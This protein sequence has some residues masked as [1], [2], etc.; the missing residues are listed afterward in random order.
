MVL[1][2]YKSL[3]EKFV[4]LKSVSTDSAFNAEIKKTADWLK[5]LLKENGF[6][7]EIWQGPNSNPVVYGSY[8]VSPGAKTTL[9]YGHY[10]VQPASKKDGWAFEPFELTEKNGRLYGRGVVDN[11]GQVL[12]H[13]YTVIK[14]IKQ[15]K[16]KQ[17]VKFLIEGNEETSNEDL[18]EL[19]KRYKGKLKTDYILISDG[20]M[21]HGNPVVEYSLRGGFNT[22][23]VYKTAKTNLHSG[24]FGGAIPNAALVLTKFVAK[25][26]DQ[27]G[28]VKIPGFYDG[29]DPITNQQ[30]KDNHN[31][32]KNGNEIFQLT[33]AKKLTL[34]KDEDFYTKT[35][36]TPTIQITG[37]KS[38]YIDEG[39]ANIVP[40]E[41]EVR[42]NFRTV[43]S[44]NNGKILKAFKKMIKT[45][46][47][48]YV[49]YVFSNTEPY[50]WVKVNTSSEIFDKTREML[51]R[52]YGLAPLTKP[53]GGGIPVVS[54][55]KEILGKESLLISLGNDDCNMHGVNENYL[56]DLA[57]RGLKFSEM[58]FSSEL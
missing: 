27:Y 39:Y 34:S 41:A 48:N 15:N 12:T 14:L 36:L 25:L 7:T 43:S 50:N 52:A 18:G 31:L 4:T 13:I 11:K 37:F 44:Q 33:G 55:F 22:K 6:K 19:I 32:I 51:K 21:P 40:C 23:L 28:N 9:V 47:P 1:K 20:E 24:L 58:F 29:I 57:E 54:D 10:D 3:L 8:E 16:L 38:G 5:S 35:G 56:I 17:N 53:V 46:T 49:D 2:E 45:E 30:K 26:F 42:I